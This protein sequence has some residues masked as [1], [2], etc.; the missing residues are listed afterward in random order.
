MLPETHLSWDAETAK[1]RP[2]CIHPE[3]ICLAVWDPQ[4]KKGYLLTPWEDDIAS[5]VEGCLD[6]AIAG[7]L[8]I[9]NQTMH[10]DMHVLCRMYPHLWKKTI[11]AYR[12][13]NLLVTEHRAML[14]E[15]QTHGNIDFELNRDGSGTSLEYNHAALCKRWL[16]K[17][18][19]EGKSGPDSWRTRYIELKGKPKATW[20]KEAR[21]YA[22]NDAM[23]SYQVWREI[24]DANPRVLAAS[25]ESERNAARGAFAAAKVTQK[26]LRLDPFAAQELLEQ[27]RNQINE[28]GLL[29]KYGFLSEPKPSGP[30]KNRQKAHVEDCK[31]KKGCGCPLKIKFWEKQTRKDKVIKTFLIEWIAKHDPE[32]SIPLTKG[33]RK[34]YEEKYDVAK[35]QL[36]VNDPWFQ[37]NPT[38]MQ[39]ENE[40]LEELLEPVVDEE[41]PEI[42]QL[43]LD[44]LKWKK[45]DKLWTSFLPGM[46]WDVGHQA[47]GK[48]LFPKAHD[49]LIWPNRVHG[50]YGIMKKTQRMSG[51]GGKMYPSA[52]HQQQDPRVRSSYIADPGN[53]LLTVDYASLEL[54]SAAAAMKRD[55]GYSSLYD[56]LVLGRDPHGFLG[57]VLAVNMATEKHVKGC[58]KAFVDAL[59]A[60]KPGLPRLDAFEAFKASDNE[61][62][63]EFYGSWRTFAK[64]VGLGF[65][66]GLGFRTMRALAFAQYG[67]DIT[68][69]QAKEAK[70]IWF[71]TFPEFEEYLNGWIHGQKDGEFEGKYWYASPLGAMRRNCSY[72]AALNGNALQT[73]PAEGIREVAFELV[74]ACEDP[75]SPLY[76]ASVVAIIHDEVILQVPIR[77]DYDHTIAAIDETQRIMV[78]TMTERLGIKVKVEAEAMYRWYKKLPKDKDWAQGHRGFDPYRPIDPAPLYPL[79]PAIYSPEG[80]KVQLHQ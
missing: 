66:G 20:P 4:A 42:K 72:T 58:T 11:A 68:D 18:V 19:S 31:R 13:G 36:P 28:I 52:N 23:E 64:P 38:H 35:R 12:A 40:T 60:A 47:S 1:I 79:T 9:V 51:W 3:L 21:E 45:A 15:L 54:Y 8:L 37:E 48:G 59:W 57:S 70:K 44:Y 30:T 61:A 53:I 27:T 29:R 50:N 63:Q 80:P 33:G 71:E 25:L 77:A 6:Q 16:F 69:E 5:Y 41:D 75:D 10:F 17:D 43:I 56:L 22:L 76:G 34:K 74:A 67:V 62:D 46:M 78:E 39:T 24:T 26:G 65:P 49:Q 14:L 73:P 7:E 55:L 2:E 32:R